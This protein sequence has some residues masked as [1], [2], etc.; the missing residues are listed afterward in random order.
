[1]LFFF[2]F[3]A[4]DGIRDATVTGVQT[5]ALPISC[6]RAYARGEWRRPFFEWRDEAP[7][8]WMEAPV[9][10]RAPQS[11]HLP[12]PLW[13]LPPASPRAPTTERAYWIH[14]PLLTAPIHAAA[15]MS[16]GRTAPEIPRIDG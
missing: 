7:N 4:E 13:P 1:M 5:C 3:Q 8:R 15:R 11:P 10:P 12:Q 9:K 6:A 2:F 16:L 14:P